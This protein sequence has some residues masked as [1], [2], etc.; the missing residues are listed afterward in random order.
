MIYNGTYETKKVDKDFHIK[1]FVLHYKKYL[2]LY[3]VKA[4]EKKFNEI[5]D[6][7]R[8]EILKIDSVEKNTLFICGADISRYVFLSAFSRMPRLVS[9]RLMNV[10][11]LQDVWW[12]NSNSDNVKKE[13][14]EV[15]HS[16]QD[17]REDVL[18]IFIDSSMFTNDGSAKI[19]NTVL[20][21]RADRVN[22]RYESLITWVFYRGS[23]EN[24]KNDKSMSLVYDFFISDPVHYQVVDLSSLSGILQGVDKLK[25]DNTQ[26]SLK[27]IY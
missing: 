14:E 23:V 7:T 16:E 10:M 1:N 15:L 19:V 2:D 8:G 6:T 12:Q 11:D 5:L 25:I 18:C 21:S 26:K 22:K 27:D 13:D 20:S 17:I 4:D 3:L 9:N 24:L